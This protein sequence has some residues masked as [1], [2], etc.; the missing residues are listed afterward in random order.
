MMDG[1]FF[2]VGKGAWNDTCVVVHLILCGY[3]MTGVG[4]RWTNQGLN[5]PEYT[6]VYIYIYIFVRGMIDQ[7]DH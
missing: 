1:F 5:S 6:W 4:D 7:L 3:R 2:L